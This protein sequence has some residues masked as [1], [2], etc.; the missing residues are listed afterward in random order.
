MK[1]S[2][3]LKVMD[4]DDDI[5][6]YDYNKSLYKSIANEPIFCGNIRKIYK[7]NPLNKCHIKYLI[8]CDNRILV[9]ISIDE[10][11]ENGNNN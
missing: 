5:I 6:I 3:L 8:P 10:R 4:K 9:E 11:S 1:L 2:Q 7:D